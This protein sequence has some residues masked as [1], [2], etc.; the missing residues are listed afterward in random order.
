MTILGAVIGGALG[1][2]GAKKSSDAAKQAAR[3]RNEAVD[4]QYKYD[5]QAWQ[6][7][8]DAA[9][10]DREY[11]VKEIQMRAEQEGQLAAYKDAQQA[12]SYN[13][14][15]QIRNQQQDTN[16]RMYAKSE[17]IYVNQLGINAAEE[18][19]ARLNEKRQLK[20][21]TTKNLYEQNDAY[22]EALQ[23]EGAIRAR[24]VTGRT[25]EKLTSV[26]A[27][28]AAQTLTML[29][30][31]LDNATVESQA[32]MRA[33]TRD[34]SVADLNAYAAR[35]LDPGTLPMPIAPLP[36]PQA[37]FMYPRVFEDYDFGP[38]PIR[39]A[40]TSP[41]AAAAAVWGTSITSLAGTATSIVNQITPK[42]GN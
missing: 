16:E 30:L 26:A 18:R 21:I 40:M 37:Q 13:Y 31:S 34:R 3:D 33:I 6:M 38:Q 36:T 29:D 27:L 9:I 11:A 20:E 5:V 41:S 14:N 1:L 7:Q 32:T 35:M 17:D 28:K 25:T 12:Q 15:L 10:A 4:A 22:L 39:G 2:Y 42:L 19:E 8:K 24:G 23:A